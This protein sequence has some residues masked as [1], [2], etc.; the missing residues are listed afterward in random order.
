MAECQ[1]VGLLGFFALLPL[2]TCLQ[3]DS[4]QIPS[5][6][7]LPHPGTSWSGSVPGPVW[8]VQRTGETPPAAGWSPDP[9]RWLWWSSPS[10]PWC[11]GRKIISYMQKKITGTYGKKKCKCVCPTKLIRTVCVCF[12]VCVCVFW[13]SSTI[14]LNHDRWYSMCTCITVCIHKSDCMSAFECVCVCVFSAKTKPA[15]QPMSH[16]NSITRLIAM[17]TVELCH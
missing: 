3:T 10:G 9:C 1:S 16:N 2:H 13:R 8:A 5:P 4:L 17:A 11:K 6:L 15:R 12:F 14:T 7:L